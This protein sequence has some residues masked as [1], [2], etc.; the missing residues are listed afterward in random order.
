MP[1]AHMVS[2]ALS[3]STP[4]GPLPF[5]P[6]QARQILNAEEMRRAI[7]RIAHE[8]LEHTE[9]ARDTLLVGLYAEGV[10]LAERLAQLILSFEGVAVPTGCLD[11][12]AFRDDVQARGPFREAGPTILPGA[13]TGQTVVLV[14]DVI[15]TGRSL[16]A[17]IDGL[18]TYG[19]PSRV[20]AAVLI[21]RGHRELPI[22]AD[23]VGK[24][25]PTAHD[26][27]VRVLLRE[28]HGEDG[29]YLIREE[30]QR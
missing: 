18:F 1:R 16:R 8:I 4:S 25:V 6:Q 29:V 15:Y 24:N 17:A 30:G 2:P 21:D 19:R 3:T 28:L 7:A 13:I 9:G 5:D 23:Y 22:R 14:D 12:G 10:P 11:F 20:Q 26:E 27:W